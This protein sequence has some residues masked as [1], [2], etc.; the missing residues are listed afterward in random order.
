VQKLYRSSWQGCLQQPV[1]MDRVPSEHYVGHQ[2]AEKLLCRCLGHC[3]IRDLWG[4]FADV[5]GNFSWKAPMVL[6][7]YMWTPF[8]LTLL[9]TFH[10]ISESSGD[11]FYAHRVQFRLLLKPDALWFS[12]AVLLFLWL[13]CRPVCKPALMRLHCFRTVQ[14]F[15][16]FRKVHCFQLFSNSS[17]LFSIVFEQFNTFEQLCINFTNEKLQQFFNHH[18]FVLEQEEYKKE[19][20][21]WEFID[22]GMDLQ[23]CIE[24]LEKVEKFLVLITG[25]TNFLT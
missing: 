20:I 2:A 24:L 11:L 10:R 7:L 8:S 17:A 4:K 14:C 23:D 25:A 21:E 13:W 18:M 9:K 3:W 12:L 22:F 19:G 1:P 16:C 6:N 15:N 5:S